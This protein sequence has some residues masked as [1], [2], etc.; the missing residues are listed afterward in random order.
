[1]VASLIHTI[2]THTGD[3]TGVAYTQGKLATISGDKT[4]RLWNTE[5]YS[6][7]PCSPLLGHTYIIHFCTFSA[8][9][10]MLATCSTDGTM[11][12][13][14]TKTGQVT[15]EI[16]HAS[17][18]AIRVCKFSPDSTH[19][20][21]G[22]EDDT[23]CMWE[24]LTK[25]LVRSYTGLEDT[26]VGLAYSPDGHFLVSGSS[27]GDIHV[28]DA[29][30]GHGRCLS[31]KVDA[32]DLGVTCCEFSPTFGT[33]CKE[34]ISV[35]H[36]LLATGGKDHLVKLWKFKAKVGSI[37][38]LMKCQSELIGHTDTVVSCAF[39]PA[40]DLLASGSFDKSVRLWD[41]MR[42]IAFFA[43]ENS[44]ERILTC[45]AFSTDGCYLATGS[46]DKTVKIWK[47]T[48]TSR[49]MEGLSGY[50]EPEQ[51]EGSPVDVHPMAAWTVEDVVQW[52]G[53]LGLAQYGEVFQAQAID[54]TELVGLASA[55]LKSIG[56][57]ALGHR[58]KIL[59]SRDAREINP[60][61]QTLSVPVMA[62]SGERVG[63]KCVDF[64][65]H[66]ASPQ[67]SQAQLS[68]ST[69]QPV[70]SA[71]CLQWT[72]H[73]VV[74]WLG[75]LGMPQY[76][77]SFQQ[78][79]ID[80]RELFSLSDADLQSIIGISA[81]GHRNKILRSRD[82]ATTKVA[83]IKPKGHPSV[84]AFESSQNE[85]LCPI[86]MEIMHDPVIAADGYTY[87]RSAILAWF[88]KGKDRS[89]MTNAVLPHKSVTPNRTLKM[90]IQK[91][92]EQCGK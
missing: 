84:S 44:H 15:G 92:L 66:N 7:L 91:H 34:N 55:H 37:E 36:L 48:D 72:V 49:I 62:Q 1:M 65:G 83:P 50:E 30:F 71:P 63:W 85:F 27:N 9:G 35:A 53:K 61:D 52:L 4:V 5:D 77:D 14:D 20:V 29:S 45:C 54:G 8:F 67:Q 80:G 28:W 87:D 12:L 89:P 33:A 81:M 16:Q 41:P 3:I 11:K 64:R 59:R 88:E 68:A 25:K 39:S 18:S 42:G 76:A 43:I 74:Q 6:E 19:I 73:D 78:H 32:H 75:T 51:N 38:V 60:E 23:I 46:M 82:K 40:G 57:E 31:L 86:T 10:S 24:V 69:S 26:V 17:K 70:S 22:S 79:A 90:L 47:L 13:W 58:N 2:K 21:T 56:V